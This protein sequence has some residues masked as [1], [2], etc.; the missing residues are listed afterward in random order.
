MFDD[1]VPSAEYKIENRPRLPVDMLKWAKQARNG[2]WVFCC[3][4]GEEHWEE[5]A[6]ALD[7][8]L[9]R[10]EEEPKKYTDEFVKNAWEELHS[11]WWEE[12]KWQ[13]KDVLRA[14]NK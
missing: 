3:A 8:L 2:L 7:T 13:V 12:L 10:N 9:R 6:E 14:C 1:Y 11:R 5:R 4:Y